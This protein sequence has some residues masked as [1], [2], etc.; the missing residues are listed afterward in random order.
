MNLKKTTLLAS[1]ALTAAGFA[2]GIGV[3][4]TP[5]GAKE[6]KIATFMG[7]PHFLNKVA[8][9]NLAKAIGKE[10]GGETTAK[11]F[12]SGQLGKG[13]VQQYKRV[14]DNVAEISFGIQGYTPTIFPRTVIVGQP[15]VGTTAGE[16]TGKLWSVY[17]KFLM[18]EYKNVKV[19]GLWANTPPVI[20][21]RTKLVKKLSDV[22]GMKLRALAPEN[23]PQMNAWGAS[24]IFMPIS[25]TYDALDKGVIDATFTAINALF[26]PWRFSESS[27]FVTD[28]M[29]KPSAIFWLAMNRKVWDGLPAKSKAAINGLTGQKF[30]MDTAIGWAKPDVVALARAKKGDVGLKY[31]VLSKAEAAKFDAATAKSVEAFLAK[32]EANGIPARAIYAAITK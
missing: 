21:S 24:G 1:A 30:S 27:K 2:L 3:A 16:I 4:T 13:P 6:L 23:I 25:R 32:S 18:P 15:G 8:F 20:I 31:H 11:L 5:A 29:R 22:K 17:D 14:I 28:G 19:L 9:T 12:A 10:T 7:P 26:R